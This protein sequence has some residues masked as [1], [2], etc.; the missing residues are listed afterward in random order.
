MKRTILQPR[1]QHK[2]MKV[3]KGVPK[4]TIIEDV[5]ELV[6]EKAQDCEAESWHD[7]ENK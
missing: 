2:K 6:I 3:H 1:G 4:F 5:V 7:V